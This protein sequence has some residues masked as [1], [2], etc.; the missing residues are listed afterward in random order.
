MFY[1]MSCLMHSGM[2]LTGQMREALLQG[3]KHIARESKSQARI[4]EPNFEGYVE[5]NLQ[6]VS[7]GSIAGVKFTAKLDTEKGT[8]KVEFVVPE[9]ELD[10]P[11][12]P[13]EKYFWVDLPPTPQRM[14]HKASMN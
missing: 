6:V 9:F 5:T 8:T 1:R 10:L 3:A 7:F 4:S 13:N 14:A 2:P 11:E 12:N